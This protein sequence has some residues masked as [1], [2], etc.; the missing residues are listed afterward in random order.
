[1]VPSDRIVG[2]RSHEGHEEEKKPGKECNTEYT[3]STEKQGKTT[4]VKNIRLTT[5][6]CL[7]L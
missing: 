5:A 6:L 3:E 4:L 2:P 1:M 7:A